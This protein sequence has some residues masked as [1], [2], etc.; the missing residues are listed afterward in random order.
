MK[1][2][3][4]END[5][6]NSISLSRVWTDFWIQNSRFFPDFFQ[7]NNFFFQTHSYQNKLAIETLKK[8]QE[9]SFI[10]DALPTY[11]WDWIWLDQ[12]EK[13]FTCKST[14]CSFR[15]NFLPF[16]PDFI[17]V[18][19]TSS[20]SGKLLDKFQDFFKNSRLCTDPVFLPLK[21]IWKSI[22]LTAIS[23]EDMNS[24]IIIEVYLSSN[25]NICRL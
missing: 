15:K 25:Y 6:S 22:L 7:N 3:R 16:F 14:C 2:V 10:N 12:K 21:S 5:N 1:G 13:T 23:L 8:E 20:R 17:S 11:R 9:Q 4:V 24:S 18:F 19:Q